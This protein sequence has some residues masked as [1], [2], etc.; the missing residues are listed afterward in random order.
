MMHGRK[1]IK[2]Y[3]QSHR[4]EIIIPLSIM[5]FLFTYKIYS[6]ALTRGDVNAACVR[7]LTDETWNTKAT[8]GELTSKTVVQLFTITKRRTKCDVAEEVA[9]LCGWVLLVALWADKL[10]R[11]LCCR[12]TSPSFWTK[13]RAY[14]FRQTTLISESDIMLHA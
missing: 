14:I 7:I 6:L 10:Q 3:L 8:V 9:F 13:T 2:S 11:M 5:M 4:H 12:I 1:N